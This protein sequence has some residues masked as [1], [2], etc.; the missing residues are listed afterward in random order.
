M[1]DYTM[2]VVIFQRNVFKERASTIN[3]YI[4]RAMNGY[5]MVVV[6]QFQRNV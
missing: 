3:D 5:T 2:V 6:I 4:G 1:N